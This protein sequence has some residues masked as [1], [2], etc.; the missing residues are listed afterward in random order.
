MGSGFPSPLS[1]HN[2]M[3]VVYF[4]LF[5]VF[6]LIETAGLEARAPQKALFPGGKKVE[7][8]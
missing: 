6:R 1:F 4:K 8:P 2:M 7:D 3:R 5:K